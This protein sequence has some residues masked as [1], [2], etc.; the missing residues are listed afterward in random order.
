MLGENGLIALAVGTFI[1]AFDVRRQRNMAE[2]LEM[3]ADAALVMRNE[4]QGTQAKLTARKN[5]GL[6]F[7]VT[8]ENPLPNLNLAARPDKCLPRLS[9]KLA[10]EE[11][12]DF[13]SQMLRL[14]GPRGRLRTDARTPSEQARR[15]DARIVEDEE[16]VTTQE[17]GKFREEAVFENS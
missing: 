7:P 8:K 13:P 5:F 11:D 3:P 6:Q 9:I 12:F 17:T 14:C 15:D 2:A 1:G 10:G 16:F 4:T